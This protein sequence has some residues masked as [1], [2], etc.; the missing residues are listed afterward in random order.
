[1]S[2][3]STWRTV[4]EAFDKPQ[5][6]LDDDLIALIEAEAKEMDKPE[7]DKVRIS[8]SWSIFLAI[9]LCYISSIAIGYFSAMVHYGGKSNDG[10]ATRPPNLATSFTDASYTA[11]ISWLILFI[12]VFIASMGSL[13]F[14]LSRL[15]WG[16]SAA[17]D[18]TLWKYLMYFLFGGMCILSFFPGWYYG[19]AHFY[20]DAPVEYLSKDQQKSYDEMLDYADS[21]MVYGVGVVGGACTFIIGWIIWWQAKW[22]TVTDTSSSDSVA[23]SRTPMIDHSVSL[24]SALKGTPARD[25]KTILTTDKLKRV[26][27]QQ[28]R[29][30]LEGLIKDWIPKPQFLQEQWIYW[31]QKRPDGDMIENIEE[32]LKTLGSISEKARTEINQMFRDPKKQFTDS[33]WTKLDREREYAERI[34]QQAEAFAAERRQTEQQQRQQEQ[35]IQNARATAA[36][37]QQLVQSI[38]QRIGIL[39][40]KDNRTNDEQAELDRLIVQQ[41]EMD[42]N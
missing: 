12:V 5:V 11:G 20:Y 13:L 36:K 30:V 19:K 4:R 42:A 18:K 27:A 17:T 16:D 23:T 22:E 29:K 38:D 33:D 37:W 25:L 34:A 6:E 28:R 1:M 9:V 31:I 7:K 24:M 10:S 41:A 32:T 8:P 15:N 35:N 39:Q 26:R 2:G 21:L 40:R 14:D 3:S